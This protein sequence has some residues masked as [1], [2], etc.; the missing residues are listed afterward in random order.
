MKNGRITTQPEH[1]T[2]LM[3]HEA[4]SFLRDCRKI[5]QTCEMVLHN[6]QPSHGYLVYVHFWVVSK[7]DK[8]NLESVAELIRSNGF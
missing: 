6:K 7:I 1:N 8:V 4:N 5:S 2:K 3:C